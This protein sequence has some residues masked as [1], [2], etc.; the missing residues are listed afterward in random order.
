MTVSVVNGFL[1]FSSCDVVKAEKGV[2]P[3]PKTDP[4]GQVIKTDAAGQPVSKK[5]T[6]GPAVIYGGSLA[7]R[8]S[9][10]QASATQGSATQGSSATSAAAS[11]AS[12][13][14]SQSYTFETV[15]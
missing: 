12:S 15:A 9:G 10:V 8:I 14:S 2:N 6:D 1:C 4:S 3:H 5:R 13:A 11:S 7:S